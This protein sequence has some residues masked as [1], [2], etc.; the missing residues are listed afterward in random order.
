VGERK[1]TSPLAETSKG[2]NKVMMRIQ[3]TILCWY[4]ETTEAFLKN[5]KIVGFLAVCKDERLPIHPSPCPAMLLL[6]VCIDDW[7]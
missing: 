5:Q 3:Q 7:F 6:N 1:P 2:R 4:D